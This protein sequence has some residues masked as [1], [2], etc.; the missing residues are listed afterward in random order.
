MPKRVCS[1]GSVLKYNDIPNEIEYLFISDTE[2]NDFEG[3]IDAEDVYM[4]M[5]SFFKCPNCNRLWVFWNG[6]DKPPQ[7][8]MP[9]MHNNME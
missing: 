9:I 6:F 4:K 1:C 2:Y 8:Y 3:N 7:E 5:K